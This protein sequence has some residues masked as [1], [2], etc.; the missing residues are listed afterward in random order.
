MAE[1][2]NPADH[3]ESKDFF[4]TL[5][6]YDEDPID[7]P[8]ESFF[9]S[10]N[11]QT[12]EFPDLGLLEASVGSGSDAASTVIEGVLDSVI[13]QGVLPRKVATVHPFSL[14]NKGSGQPVGIRL[15][16]FGLL[17]SV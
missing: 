4:K 15:A 10:D 1:R 12:T 3:E 11:T 8:F 6:F 2:D 13:E 5:S 17:Y 16:K 7:L 14:N 9:D